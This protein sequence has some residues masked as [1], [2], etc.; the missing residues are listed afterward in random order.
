MTRHLQ[1]M[2]RDGRRSRLSASGRGLRLAAVLFLAAASG[3]AEP[4]AL[5]FGG[6]YDP[7][8][9]PDNNRGYYRVDLADGSYEQVLA[10]EGPPWPADMDFDDDGVLFATH[11]NSGTVDVLRIDPTDGSWTLVTSAIVDPQ[12]A[13]ALA[14][15]D[16]VV[17]VGRVE[18]S[19][20]AYTSYLLHLDPDSGAILHEVALD[21]QSGLRLEALAS[22]HGELWAITDG[23]VERVDPI[24]GSTTSAQTVSFAENPRDAAFAAGGAL[25]V[26]GLGGSPLPELFYYSYQRVDVDTGQTVVTDHHPVGDAQAGSALPGLAIFAG[27]QTAVVD[28]PALGTAGS[29]ALLVLLSLASLLT[30][31]RSR[32][33]GSSPV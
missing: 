16:G 2:S 7:A 23:G 15:G 10:F 21:L 25:W 29:S 12:G 11:W 33:Q 13:M 24:A 14:V 28:V 4:F 6:I 9:Y 17:Y 18:G 20:P 8:T 22:R 3:R 27:Q 31:R 1:P 19:Y 26:S 30:F 32:R 5:S